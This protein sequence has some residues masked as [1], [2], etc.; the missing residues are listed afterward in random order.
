MPNVVTTL[1]KRKKASPP[2]PN[3]MGGGTRKPR[4][5]F[6]TLLLNLCIE[7]SRSDLFRKL[8]QMKQAMQETETVMEENL[9]LEGSPTRFNLQ[10]TGCEVIHMF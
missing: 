4:I 3:L 5:E 9:V 7:S 8:R 6:D 1:K 2:S 10:R